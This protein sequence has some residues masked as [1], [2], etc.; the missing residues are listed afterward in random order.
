[1]LYEVHIV[2]QVWSFYQTS[3]QLCQVP[4]IHLSIT[5]NNL[6]DSSVIIAGNTTIVVIAI[7][8]KINIEFNLIERCKATRLQN[9]TKYELYDIIEIGFIYLF[10][11]ED[12][13]MSHL[14]LYDYLIFDYLIFENGYQL[15]KGF[16]IRTVFY[17]VKTLKN[18]IT[19]N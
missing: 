19:Q 5:I 9:F 10:Q 3:V 17:K 4:L 8:Y 11:L 14:S 15:Y 18:T 6:K 1:M 7:S 16:H 13:L 12:D 2:L